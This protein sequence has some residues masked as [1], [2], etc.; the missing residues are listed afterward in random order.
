MMVS[1]WLNVKFVVCGCTPAAKVFQMLDPSQMISHAAIVYVY[2]DCCQ[3]LCT[4]K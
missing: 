4:L 1:V 2:L 3:L